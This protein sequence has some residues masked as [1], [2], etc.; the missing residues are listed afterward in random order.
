MQKGLAILIQDADLYGP[1]VQVKATVEFV[2]FDV[3]SHHEAASVGMSDAGRA[4]AMK[5]KLQTATVRSLA[6]LTY[7]PRRRCRVDDALKANSR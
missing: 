2:L 1:G 3:E 7:G 6:A 5:D 4:G